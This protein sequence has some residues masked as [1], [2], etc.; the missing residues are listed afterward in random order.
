MMK[1]GL[2]LI[3]LLKNCVGCLEIKFLEIFIN[4]CGHKILKIKN[5]INKSENFIV[6]AKK[7]QILEIFTNF[8]NFLF[9]RVISKTFQNYF[10][11]LK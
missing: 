9:F 6:I 3:K 5:L 1:F 10:K 2:N 11:L 4:I 7:M 8:L